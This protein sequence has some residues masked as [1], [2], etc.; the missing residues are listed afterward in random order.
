M[1]PLSPD[2]FASFMNVAVAP[3]L[4]RTDA[5]CSSPPTYGTSCR[6]R[7]LALRGA[8]GRR[9][10]R[11]APRHASA[12]HARTRGRST[13]AEE[14]HER[15]GRPGTGGT[16]ALPRCRG[17]SRHHSSPAPHSSTPNG[18]P[19]A[20]ASPH[21]HAAPAAWRWRV[22]GA[23]IPLAPLRRPA[24]PLLFLH[25]L[26]ARHCAAAGRFREIPSI[27]GHALCLR[28]PA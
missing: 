10:A 24:P 17:R 28:T 16:D 5:P 26:P 21:P 25:P 9:R 27:G 7:G 22:A 23:Q 6:R 11:T 19:I 18:L 8:G 4:P 2:K 12:D 1:L 15:A 13:H 14:A 3:S 20:S